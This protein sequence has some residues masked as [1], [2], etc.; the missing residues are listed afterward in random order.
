MNGVNRFGVNRMQ[1][2]KKLNTKQLFLKLAYDELNPDLTTLDGLERGL[3]NWYCFKYEVP[4][5][6]DKLNS[7][8]LEELIILQMMHKIRENPSIAA[9]A[10]GEADEYEDWLKKEM[11]DDYLSTEQMI[12]REEKNKFKMKDDLPNVITTDFE[13]L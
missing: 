5:N 7:M 13:D 9:E 10:N 1:P 6:D 4:P 8:T 11:G 3:K 12:E 2:K